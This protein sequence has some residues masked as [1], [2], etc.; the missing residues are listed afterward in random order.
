MEELAR[1]PGRDKRVHTAL[2]A[3]LAVLL[4]RLLG[5]PRRAHPLVGYGRLAALVEA[6]LNRVALHPNAARL[7]GGMAVAVLLAPFI[8]LSAVATHIPVMAP[9]M[10]VLILY[11][12]LGGQSLMQHARRVM[13]ALNAGDLPRARAHVGRLVSRDTGAMQHAEVARATI[14]SVLENGNDAVFGALFWFA[15]AGVPGAALYRLSN[16]LDAMWGYRTPRYRYFGWA[17]ARLDDLLNLIPARLTA[18]T[19]V[20]LGHHTLAWQCWHTQGR[21]WESPNA[22]PVMAAGAGALD[23]R[24]GGA[25]FYHGALKQRPTLGTEVPPAAA[26]IERAVHL[27]QQGVVL[28]LVVLLGSA[29]GGWWLA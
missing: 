23:V 24:L 25:A 13:Q 28:W 2:I 11:L 29:L 19:Y 4:D 17:A 9:A 16:T 26:D 12:A 8:M 3:L 22:G 6:R 21:A 14:E 1:H 18:L 5:E 10:E 27:V 7:L 20:L 15:V